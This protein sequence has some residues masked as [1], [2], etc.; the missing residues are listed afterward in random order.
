MAFSDKPGFAEFGQLFY[1]FGIGPDREF[2]RAPDH[3]KGRLAGFRAVL[4]GV[5]F[6]HVELFVLL[7]M[8][9]HSNTD[10]P[11]P[12]QLTVQLIAR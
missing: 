7:R 4:R 5:D 9:C 2:V 12:H 6:D 8:E 10:F 3:G 1:N 11:I